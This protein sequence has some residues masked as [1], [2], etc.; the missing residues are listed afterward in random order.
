MVYCGL[1][2]SDGQDFTEL[3]EALEKL[4]INDPSFD[5][6][7]ETSD[8]L[9]FGFRCGFLG[10]LHMEIIQ[11]RLEQEADIDLVQ[12]APNVTYQVTTKQGQQLEIH[13]PQEVP[14]AGDIEE[15]RQ[16]VVRVN[17][18]LPTEA[19]GTLMKLCQDRR[20]VHR[21]TEYISPTRA[22]LRYEL[23]LAEVIYD[24]HDKLKSATRG[25]G[26]MDYELIGYFP[27]ELVR[28]DIL[29]NGTRV[30]ALSIICEKA[31]ADRRG[32]AVTKKLKSE[33]DRHMFEVAVQAAVGSRV[34][35]R[36]RPG[37]A[38][39]RDREM[40][41]R[42]YHPQT[43]TVGETA[44]R[45]EAHE[46]DR[47]G[48]HPAEGL[49]GRARD[50]QRQEIGRF[51]VRGSWWVGEL[52]VAVSQTEKT[53]ARRRRWIGGLVLVVVLMLL[54][55]R[56]TLIQ[57]WLRPV[58]ITGGS[59]AE[60]LY[61]PHFPVTCH[62]CGWSFRCGSEYPPT[63]DLAT[64]PNCGCGDNR[65]DSGTAGARPT[66]LDRSL[67]QDGV[68]TPHVA[69][70]RFSRTWRRRVADRETPRGS[71]ARTCGDSRRRCV[72]RRPDPAEDPRRTSRSPH[73]G[74]QRPVPLA[75][76]QPLAAR[77]SRFEL[78]PTAPAMSPSLQRTPL[79]PSTG[80]TTR[81]GLAGPT[82][83]PDVDRTQSVPILDHDPYNQSL[84][85][86][87]TCIRFRTSC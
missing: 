4:S 36:N 50:G 55:L 86:R 69:G 45:Q 44:G 60:A 41:R 26:T 8:A 21:A 22:M 68:R 31:D 76:G 74:S 65:V 28:L 33:I 12:T 27:A 42:R 1:Y 72:P 19:I 38:Q 20:G 37:H 82:G 51:V 87:E 85:A 83:A 58:R 30:D 52:V 13:R 17:F 9:G 2:P 59:M 73:P 18:I 40:L 43:E 64:C 6:Q 53:S 49:P 70:R 7:P 75:A 48:R 34:I 5:F 29:V 81:S 78:A 10:L 57:G 47:P 67:G 62:E 39:E 63:D 11:Q 56:I 14:D 23:P 24:L 61:G 32:R 15:F 16:P 77:T 79:Q 80:S 71:R 25:Y 54:V 3:R 66:R 84:S 46:V 35:A